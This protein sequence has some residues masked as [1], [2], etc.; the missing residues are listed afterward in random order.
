MNK[1]TEE[2]VEKSD[3]AAM[4]SVPMTQF[5]NI[6]DDYRLGPLK[7]LFNSFHSVS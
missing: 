4:P 5:Q 1:E 3:Y 6:V 7:V 2:A